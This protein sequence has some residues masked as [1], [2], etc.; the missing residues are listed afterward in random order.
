M[1]APYKPEKV[2][3]FYSS[4]SSGN[5]GTWVPMS[6]VGGNNP[7]GRVAPVALFYSSDGSGNDGTWLPMSN[8]SG[9]GAGGATL[10]Q[11][12]TPGVK[13]SQLSPAVNLT[14]IFDFVPP[15]NVSATKIT[16][17]VAVADNTA[18][19]YDIG[20]YSPTG[21]LLTHTGALAGTTFAPSTGAKTYNLL[22]TANLQG[23]TRYVLSYTGNAAVVA[24]S[25]CGAS[26]LAFPNVQPAANSATVGGVLNN[27][28]TLPADA[29][30]DGAGILLFSLHN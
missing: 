14:R 20:I 15:G 6:G 29:W 25:T 21:T 26:L 5:D 27:S 18:D 22:S 16:V 23:G 11:Y 28:I 4:D 12:V 30:S 10:S 2:G 1:T 24:L 8:F 9:G 3:A 13:T 7:A 17:S 19:L